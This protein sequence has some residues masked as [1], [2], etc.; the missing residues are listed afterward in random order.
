V[1]AA[2]ER[3]LAAADADITT[4]LT[5]ELPQAKSIDERIS[6]DRMLTAGGSTVKTAA[7]QGARL[8]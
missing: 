1:H 6:V 8:H 2:A 5:T 4:F 3:A 7:Q